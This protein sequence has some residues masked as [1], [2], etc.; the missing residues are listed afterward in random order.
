[1]TSP[2]ILPKRQLP[3]MSP[4]QQDCVDKLRE[5]LE[6]AEQGKVYTC[7]IIVCFKKGVAAVIGGTDAGSLNLGADM[8]KR[9]ILKKIE[10]GIG[11]ERR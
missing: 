3:A 6:Q 1:M 2:I 8:L 5:A 4:A 11:D 9:D 10:P 7:G